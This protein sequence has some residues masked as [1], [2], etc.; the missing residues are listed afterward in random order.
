MQ[1]CA[2]RDLPSTEIVDEQP[3]VE[4]VSE[5]LPD[6][7]HAAWIAPGVSVRADLSMPREHERGLC[8]CDACRARSAR[9]PRFT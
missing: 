6:E 3:D 7:P 8:R 9:P 4:P 1:A 5:S 2:H